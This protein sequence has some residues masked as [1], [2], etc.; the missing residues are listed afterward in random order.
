MKSF[1]NILVL[2][3]LTYLSTGYVSF[4]NDEKDDSIEIYTI[5]DLNIG[6]IPIGTKKYFDYEEQIIKF[7]IK[8]KKDRLIRITKSS[9]LGNDFL[10]IDAEWKTGPITGFEFQFE[11]NGI[12]K[13]EQ[14]LFLVTIKIKS[15]E[16]KKHT[17]PGKYEI[18]PNIAVEY[19]DL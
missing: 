11:G 5:L 18:S 17:Q 16:V 10:I 14:D 15:V 9:E 3:V 19:A 1:K 2:I 12:Y 13:S 6:L 4:S 7:A 8:C